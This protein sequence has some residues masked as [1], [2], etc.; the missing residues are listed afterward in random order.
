MQQRPSAIV[1]L[2]NDE[3]DFLRSIYKKRRR[4]LSLVY[5]GMFAV[6]VFICVFAY[7]MDVV[8][9]EMMPKDNIH[10]ESTLGIRAINFLFLCCILLASGAYFYFK[11]V[12]PFKHDADSGVKEQIAYTIVKKNYFELTNKYYVTFDDPD[13][14]HHETDEDTWY[15]CSEGGY[16]YIYRAIRSKFV[17]EDNGRY[18]LI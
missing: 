4:F 11:K 9:N 3:Q 16:F 15:N 14:L 2:T 17:F 13:Y 18:R 8:R 10:Y 1:P 12:L 7:S 6:A 5:I